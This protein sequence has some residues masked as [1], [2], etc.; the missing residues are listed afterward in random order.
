[1][2]AVTAAGMIWHDLPAG[3]TAPAMAT[4]ALGPGG[5]H[6][7]P[8]RLLFT[9]TVVLACLSYPRWRP[10]VAP[11]RRPGLGAADPPAD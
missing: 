8:A 7:L 9:A 4:A 2:L 5:W 10:A 3:S 6:G 11:P 1:V